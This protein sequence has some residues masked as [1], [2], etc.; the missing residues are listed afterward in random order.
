MYRF[1]TSAFTRVSVSKGICNLNIEHGPLLIRHIVLFAVLLFVFG[2]AGEVHGERIDAV[3][4]PVDAMARDSLCHHG[5]TTSASA[6]QHA[7]AYNQFKTPISDVRLTSA[8]QPSFG[9]PDASQN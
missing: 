1:C 7:A 5:V 2:G 3:R 4:I 8:S 6:A 9:T